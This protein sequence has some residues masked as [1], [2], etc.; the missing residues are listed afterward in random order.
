MWKRLLVVA[1]GIAL[2]VLILMHVDREKTWAIMK[3]AD[4]KLCI[5]SLA[6]LV[7]MTSIRGGR[8]SFLLKMQG[9]AYST[10]NGFLVYMVS[11][12]WGNIT[13]GRAGDFVK[14]LYLREDLKL[15]AGL[16]MASVL[17]DRVLD[18]YLL[19]VLGG[20]GL[21]INPMPTDQVSV[22]MVLAVKVFFLILVVIT[23]L[24]FNKKIGGVFLK[25]AFQRLM[26]QE[27]REKADKLFEDFHKGMEAFYRPAVLWPVFLSL[28]AYVLAFGACYL[29]AQS[30][31]LNVSIF[32]LVFTIS[33]VNIVSLL[34]LLGMGTRDGA[35]I[36]LLGL[37]GISKEQSEAYSLLLLFVGTVLYTFV[38][39]LCTFLKPLRLKSPE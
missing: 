23:L 22:K 16:G 17:V 9:Y 30:I 5:L 20:L 3:G 28:V 38:C 13:P 27:H 32:Y 36:L 7:G 18:L 15:T 26:K 33:V 29:L 8:W 2:F 11:M 31:G 39:F 24:A 37:V 6:A 21:L 35:L 34:T 25:A 4:W 1:V 14:I 19:L 10:W 12:Y